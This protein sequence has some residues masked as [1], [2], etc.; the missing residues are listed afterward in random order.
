MLPKRFLET[1]H[2]YVKRFNKSFMIHDSLILELW[3]EHSIF[4]LEIKNTDFFQ[5]ASF[6]E[7]KNM[8]IKKN[9]KVMTNFMKNFLSAITWNK[10]LVEASCANKMH[11]EENVFLAVATS[12]GL[13]IGGVFCFLGFFQTE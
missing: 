3:H 13:R 9:L 12:E 4:I 6:K 11:T 5:I 7:S 1:S 2:K 8:V 10:S